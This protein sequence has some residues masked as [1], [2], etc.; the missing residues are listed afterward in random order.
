MLTRLRD[1]FYGLTIIVASLNAQHTGAA[2]GLITSKITARGQTV[3]TRMTLATAAGSTGLQLTMYVVSIP[4]NFPG[5]P[6]PANALVFRNG[7]LALPGADYL[8]SS[9][10]DTF[11][12]NASANLAGGDS[13]V[14]VTLP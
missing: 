2:P 1:L 11:N 7:L 8:I 6:L 12:F 14:V 4:A 10:G 3:G 13:I 9:A 5:L